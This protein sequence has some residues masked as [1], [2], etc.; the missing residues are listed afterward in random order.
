M[1]MLEKLSLLKILLYTV[2]ALYVVADQNI[3][4]YMHTNM[5]QICQK[6]PRTHMMAKYSCIS[7]Q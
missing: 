7:N 1:C 3:G 5:D 2:N 6:L 4:A